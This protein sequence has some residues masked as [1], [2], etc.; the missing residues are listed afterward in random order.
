ME[1]KPQYFLELTYRC[2]FSCIYCHNPVNEDKV[3]IKGI[4]IRRTSNAFLNELATEKWKDVISQVK[5][6]DPHYFG[7]TGGEPLLRKDL[8]V[9]VEF[10][11]R[12]DLAP[13]ILTSGHPIT[14]ERAIRL[15]E[16]GLTAARVNFMSHKWTALGQGS[17]LL[18]EIESRL[19]DAAT[20]VE[21]GVF[22]AGQ[23]VITRLIYPTSST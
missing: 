1:A 11:N 2:H 4:L 14:R 16:N 10:A 20:F 19:K 5:E 17:D 8:E 3:V 9:L 15:R 22:T 13:Y 23:V 12:N 21:A 18:R 7:F 6:L